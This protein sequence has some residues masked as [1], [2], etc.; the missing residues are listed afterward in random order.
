MAVTKRATKAVYING[1]Q[2]DQVE[3][4]IY[5]SQRFT[6]IEKNQDNE[7]RKRFKVEWEAFGRHNTSMKGKLPTSLEINF[8]SQ[9]ILP[10]MTYGTETWTLTKQIEKVGEGSN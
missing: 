10:A 9:C 8:F 7:I 2:L 3:D 6:Q 5:L 1:T 4:Y